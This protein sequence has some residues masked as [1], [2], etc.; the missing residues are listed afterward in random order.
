M[1]RLSLAP[2]F[3]VAALMPMFSAWSEPDAA[4]DAAADPGWPRE[5]K[6]DNHTVVVF[7]PQVDEWV[8]HRTLKMR[9]A[10]AVSET[11]KEE[12]AE[13]GALFAEVTTDVDSEKRQVL[14]TDRKVTKLTFPEVDDAE[15]TRLAGIMKLAMPDK[16][17]L[18]ISLDRIIAAMQFT[19]HQAKQVKASEEVP[20]IFVSEEPALLVM[21]IGDPVFQP[22]ADSGL[23]F[24]T[25]TNWDVFMTTGGTPSYFLRSDEQWF[26]TADPK[27]PR[28][29]PVDKLPDA[30]GKL[31]SDENWEDTR[32]AIPGKPASDP[33]KVFYSDRPGE[34]IVVEGAP[35]LTP[36][37]GTTLMAV[38]KAQMPTCFSTRPT[39]ATIS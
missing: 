29:Q 11:G 7:Q 1:K 26:T 27:A 39:T 4:A 8:D 25:N 10:V 38:K 5:F 9:A 31:P 15:R 17:E 36:V 21:F 28:W 6:T 2:L 3:V 19:E 14:L 23:L 18:V 37:T 35:A 20:P 12:A 16:Q 33:V 32:K 24:A 34:L 22:V 13:Y 30:F